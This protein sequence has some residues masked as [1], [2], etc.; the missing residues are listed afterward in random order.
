MNTH[1]EITDT[2]HVLIGLACSKELAHKQVILQILESILHLWVSLQK[3]QCPMGDWSLT[4]KDIATLRAKPA[5]IE[6][7]LSHI[8]LRAQPAP[9]H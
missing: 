4:E 3:K 6:A 2:E 1:Q 7:L 9:L 8:N 5:D